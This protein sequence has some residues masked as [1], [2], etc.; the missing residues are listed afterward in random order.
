MALRRGLADKRI[1]DALNEVEGGLSEAEI[2]TL[3]EDDQ[4]D[5]HAALVALIEA[6]T[7]P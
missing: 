1:I 4:S 2:V 5:L 6:T 3:V 7:A